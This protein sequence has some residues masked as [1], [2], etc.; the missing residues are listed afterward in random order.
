MSLIDYMCDILPKRKIEYKLKNEK[1]FPFSLFINKEALLRE[2]KPLTIVDY[3][4]RPLCANRSRLSIRTNQTEP[5][6]LSDCIYHYGV[7]DLNKVEYLIFK[8][9][10]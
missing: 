1:I 5:S 9:H 7:N 4:G 10:L 3:P 2:M 8:F 6:N